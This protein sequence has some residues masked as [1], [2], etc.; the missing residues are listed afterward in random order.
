MPLD[1]EIGQGVA[2]SWRC[3]TSSM[4]ASP[5]GASEQYM[6]IRMLGFTVNGCCRLCWESLRSRRANMI[7]VASKSKESR[8]HSSSKARFKARMARISACQSC[9][10]LPFAAGTIESGRHFIPVLK[11]ALSLIR[12]VSEQDLPKSYAFEFLIV[13]TRG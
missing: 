11:A 9:R 6:E 12:L 8:R 5:H 4:L 7:D 13:F 1:L 10:M 2:S 3:M